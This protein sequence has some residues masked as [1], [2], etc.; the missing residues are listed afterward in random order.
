M[1]GIQHFSNKGPGPVLGGII[2]KS[3]QEPLS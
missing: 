2:E 1:K 3:S